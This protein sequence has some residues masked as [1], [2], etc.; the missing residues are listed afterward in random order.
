MKPESGLVNIMAKSTMK[1]KLTQKK[2]FAIRV[3]IGTKFIKLGVFI[4]NTKC[5]IDHVM[6]SDI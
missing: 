6:D 2:Q 3:W 5:T 1:I 4:L